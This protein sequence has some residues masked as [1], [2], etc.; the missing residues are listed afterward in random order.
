[1]KRKKMIIG[2]SS[3]FVLL[4]IVLLG[5][6]QYMLNYSLR[7]ENRGK[8]LESSWQYMFKT[9]PYLKPWIDSL[10]QNQALKDTFIYSPDHVKLHAYYVA[11]SRP[12]AKTA[13]IVHGYTD[14]AIRMMM[15]GYLYNKKLD[16][17][18]LLP[19]LRDTGLSGGNAIQM[20]W[21]DRKDV[22]QWMEVANRIYGDSTSMGSTWNLDGCS[23]HYDGF[24]R[25]ATRLCEMFCRGL[26]I[27]QRMGPIFQ[28][29]ESTIRLASIP[30]NVHRRLVMPAGIW[31]GVQRSIRIE[32]GSPMPSAH[33]LYPW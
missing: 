5:G 18:I 13:V 32:T 7:P 11:S 23:H 27:Y 33:V 9:Y 20:G 10:K 31:M 14:N 24:G 25:T 22:T 29:T 17:N 16:F 19:D 30:V 8:N 1:M 3:I 26:R 21:L 12:T 15:I 4:I 6:S 2:T 28:R